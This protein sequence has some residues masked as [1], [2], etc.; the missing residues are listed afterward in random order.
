MTTIQTFGDSGDAA[1]QLTLTGFAIGFALAPLIAWPFL[2]ERE[3]EDDTLSTL[4]WM[5]TTSNYNVT[6]LEEE[7]QESRIYIPYTIAAVT[8]LT[9]AVVFLAFHFVK[10]PK[11]FKLFCPPKKS[12][13]E[14]LSPGTCAGG[15]ASFSVWIISLAI[16]TCA[17]HF[18]R[19]I[20]MDTYLYAIAVEGDLDF[21]SD[22]AALLDFACKLS[23]F[24]GR[25]LAIPLAYVC[26]VQ[27]I[28]HTVVYLTAL[29]GVLLATLGT[30]SATALWVISCIWMFLTGPFWGSV[31]SWLDKYIVLYTV[32]MGLID[33]GDCILGM[34]FQILAGFLYTEY[35]PET[36]F[37]IVALTGLVI[38]VVVPPMQVLASR[39]GNRYRAMEREAEEEFAE[40]S[41][42]VE[43][44]RL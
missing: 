18:V 34:I 1:I 5:T 28:F 35:Y 40:L 25:T 2:A 7:L 39:H 42:I 12:W 9:M 31:L 26:P 27:P 3:E 15:D 17:M 22:E 43:C 13:R 41:V 38:A 10:P 23:F 37:Y 33:I 30:E 20:L 24:I 29:F 8:A 21:T 6:Q 36:I 14:T 16:L 4:T 11:G 32:V 19:E 44:T